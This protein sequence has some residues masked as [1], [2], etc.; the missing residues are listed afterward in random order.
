ML[1]IST[2]EFLRAAPK[3]LEAAENGETILISRDGNGGHSVA[4]RIEK[5][6][7]KPAHDTMGVRG[8]C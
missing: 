8:S 6:D 3:Y 5:A 4:I 2:E 7:E 1:L